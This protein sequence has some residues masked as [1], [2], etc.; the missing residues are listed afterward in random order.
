MH[1][2]KT[3][4]LLLFPLL[5]SCKNIGVETMEAKVG[6]PSAS[7]KNAMAIDTS[8]TLDYL[9]GHFIP[10]KHPDFVKVDP[11]YTDHARDY[12]LHKEAWGAFKKMAD[13]AAGEGI[14]LFIKSAARNF[15]DQKGIWEAKWT[16]ARLIEEGVSAAKQYPDPKT[17]AL[18][19]LL[20]SSMPGTSRHHWGTDF[21]LNNLNPEY[22]QSG[23][24]A[25]IYQWLTANAGNF[26]FCQ[27]Y[28]PKGPERP[29]GYE[30]EQWHWSYFPLAK[31]L[32]ELARLEL[33]DENITGFLG[34]ETAQKIGV[35]EKYVLGVNKQCMPGY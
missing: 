10:S 15:E 33:K 24:G 11:A 25:R 6:D 32:T 3:F 21:D 12:Y 9:R 7:G 22:F 5:F 16:G 1:L 26:G 2:L 34:S 8:F 23:E 31:Q 19:I 4:F 27:P 28:S 29:D 17:R 35:V 18:K 13:A 30:E 20:Y 14:K